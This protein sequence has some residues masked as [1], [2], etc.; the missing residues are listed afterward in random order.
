MPNPSRT[1]AVMPAS[2]LPHMTSELTRTTARKAGANLPNTP[3]SIPSYPPYFLPAWNRRRKHSPN[4]PA[5]TTA[6]ETNPSLGKKRTNSAPDMK[7]APTT[8]PTS[9]AVSPAVFPAPCNKFDIV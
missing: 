3:A 6:K 2:I 4:N 1:V 9:V 5:A 8:V 7:P